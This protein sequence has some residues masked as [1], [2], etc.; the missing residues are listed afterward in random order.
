MILTKVNVQIIILLKIED[1]VDIGEILIENGANMEAKD[2][3]SKT[4]LVI[5]I[6]EGTIPIDHIEDT[7][8]KSIIFVSY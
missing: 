8:I 7:K 5:S 4:P 1:N 3:N 2:E 6:Q